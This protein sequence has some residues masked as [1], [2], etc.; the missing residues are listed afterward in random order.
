MPLETTLRLIG[1]VVLLLA[2]AF[3]V[4]IEFAL[5]RLRQYKP[6]ELDDSAGLQRAWKMTETLEIYLTSCQIGITSTSILLG[7]IAEPAVTES[8][9]ALFD[10]GPVGKFSSYSISIVL[11]IALINFAHTIWGEQTPT[12]LGIERAQTVARYFAIPLHWWTISMYPVLYV[13]DKLTK[14]T[15]WLFGI[16]M[17]RSWLSKEEDG[18]PS[19]GDLKTEIARLLQSDGMSDD[20]QEEVIKA[21]EIEDIPVKNIMIQREDIVTLTT[22]KSF[23]EN[24]E[25]IHEHMHTRYPLVAGT[26]D[27]FKGILYTPEIL[28]NVEDLLNGKKELDDYDWPKMVVHSGMPVSELIDRF[29]EQHHELALVEDNE[30]I[31]GLVTLTDAI[32]TIV[33]SA[34]D[35]LDLM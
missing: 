20:R 21:V 17:S 10:T 30:K 22:K 28:A 26:L 4:A 14:A 23:K 9:H 13:G 25:K 27:D 3:F 32:E 29:Q 11:S 12:Y 33:G 34:E 18:E 7:V 31:V 6:E 2:N 15:L 16:E 8:I 1:G 24:L 35:P 5:T 19:R